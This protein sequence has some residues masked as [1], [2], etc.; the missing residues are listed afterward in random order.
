MIR[1]LAWPLTALV[2]K[3]RGLFERRS[4]RRRPPVTIIVVTAPQL[5]PPPPDPLDPWKR[6]FSREETTK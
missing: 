3:L 4:F 6:H 1:V 5:S 2:W